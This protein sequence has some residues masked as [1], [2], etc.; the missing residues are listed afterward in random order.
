M[1]M[2][3]LKSFFVAVEHWK[4]IQRINSGTNVLP[5]HRKLLRLLDQ[6]QKRGREWVALSDLVTEYNAISLRR[7]S[8]S[9]STIGADL[10]KME[11]SIFVI[12]E[13]D[14]NNQRTIRVRLA[15]CGKTVLNEESSLE[16][17]RFDLYS[18]TGSPE[19]REAM[20]RFLIE[21]TKMI[22]DKIEMWKK[23]KW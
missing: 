23:E 18:H 9:E 3:V 4:E 21:A 16:D 19:D 12:R 17:E 22:S 13:R 14:P 7:F 6:A 1:F 11:T 10:K 2:P 8:T 15:P 5:R 20:E